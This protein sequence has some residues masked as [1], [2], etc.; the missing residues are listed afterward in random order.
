M[1]RCLLHGHNKRC[2]YDPYQAIPFHRNPEGPL[3]QHT[4]LKRR[5][6]SHPRLSKNI[7]AHLGLLQISAI[8]KVP[9]LRSKHQL[10]N[11]IEICSFSSS[12]NLFSTLKVVFFVFVTAPKV[13]SIS[14]LLNCHR[15]AKSKLFHTVCHKTVGVL[16]L[17]SPGLYFQSLPISK[18][19]ENQTSLF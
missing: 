17:S 18:D 19:F 14:D 11:T 13:H 7:N 9:W 2:W 8:T 4:K 3:L 15:T 5:A 1:F 10:S 12:R 6:S 16:K